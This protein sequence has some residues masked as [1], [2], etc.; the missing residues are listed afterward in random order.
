MKSTIFKA[1]ALSGLLSVSAFGLSLYDAAP[2][3]G[4]PESHAMKY[5]VYMNAGYDSNLNNESNGDR[6]DGGFV[7]YGVTASYADY[8]TVTKKTFTARLGAQL[9][10]KT[11]N[12]T[13]QRNF[14]DISVSA[15]LS[16]AFSAGSQYTGNFSLTY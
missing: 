8:E 9:Y 11:A 10:N 13:D 7:R 16:H 5:G 4:L 2:P 14:S 1:L 15:T 12:G 6:E 3:I